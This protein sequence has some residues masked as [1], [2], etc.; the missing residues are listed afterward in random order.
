[1]KTAWLA[2]VTLVASAA[3]AAENPWFSSAKF[4]WFRGNTH[5]HT[6]NA[7]ANATPDAVVRWYREHGYHFLFVTD[8]E[9]LTDVAPLNALYG[10]Q[11]RFVVL[12]GQEV[13]QMLA[14]ERHPDGMR[15]A[16]IN[17]LGTDRVVMP[18]GSEGN[19]WLARGASI[20]ELY[21][22]NFAAVR[23]AGGIPQVNHP[24]YR[25]SVKPE[26]LAPISGPF[27]I[28]IA[29]AF[30]SANN[31][32]GLDDHGTAVPSTEMFW[33]IL[34]S[35]G[36][37]VW[38]VGSDDSH[39]YTHLDDFNS[40]RPGKAWIVIR[41]TELTSATVMNAL[42]KGDF[43][44]STG[45][46]LDDYQ[47]SRESVTITLKRPRDPPRKDDRRSVTKFIGK[48]DRRFTTQFI[49]KQGRVLATVG[50]L[51]PTYTIRGDEGYVRA[52]ITDSNG[53]K[54]W[55]QPVFIK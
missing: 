9:Y 36:K 7:D 13:T 47:A 33:D 15:Q 53:M 6:L 10:A 31:L 8:H 46:T 34:L 1:M 54:A 14:D 49:G 44:A 30:P 48:D 32:G 24:N 21:V 26:D 4:K 17:G 11:N 51:K 19:L 40:E 2:L 39:D 20:A 37:T 5:A 43:Y 29:N 52:A 50:G 23:A 25:W 16:H 55:T 28:E 22:K 42:L 35:A 27:L 41:A 12:S 38:A 45:V 18:V 3:H